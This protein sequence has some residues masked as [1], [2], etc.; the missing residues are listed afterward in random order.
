MNSSI[1]CL[2]HTPIL[3]EYFTSKAYYKDINKTNPLGYEG[4]LAQVSAVLI[5][6]LW[7]KSYNSTPH[8][9]RSPGLNTPLLNAPALTPKTFKE[10]LGKF[11]EIFAGNEQHDA[12]ELLAFLLGGLSEDLNRIVEKPYM[13]APDSDGRPDSELADIWWSNHLKREMSIIVAL[14]TGQYKSLLTCRTCKYESARFEPFSFLQL[15]LPEDDYLSVSLIYYTAKEGCA[16]MKY[17]VRVR[18]DGSL[19]DVLVS[20]AKLLIQDET[21]GNL[22]KSSDPDGAESTALLHDL[23]LQRAR[24]MAI[25][26][27][28]EGYI[29]RMAANSWL[30]QD[31][32]NKDSG[33]LP[34]MH[35]Y[36]FDPNPVTQ[37]TTLNH[38][39]ENGSETIAETPHIPSPAFVAVAQRRSELLSRDVLHPLTHRVFGTPLLLRIHDIDSCTGRDLY[40]QVAR[41]LK[42]VVQRSVLRFLSVSP[43]KSYEDRKRPA[44]GG[45]NDHRL[46]SGISY[47]TLTDMEDV[48]AGPVPRYGFRLRLTS[49][50]GRR[51]LRCAWYESCIGCLIPD[52]D[53]P[54]IVGDGDSIVVDWHFAVD[55]ATNGFGCRNTNGD[56][57]IFANQTAQN[58]NSNR[59]RPPPVVYKNHSSCGVGL[60]NGKQA[61]AVTLEECLDAFSKEE[62]IPEAYC[63]KCKDFRV[64]TKRMSLWRL[65]PV[66]IIHLKRF[67]FTQ[68]MRRKLRDLVVFPTEG[69]DL[70]RIIA[71]DPLSTTADEATT[72]KL[73]ENNQ[74]G[75]SSEELK[76]TGRS[77]MLYDLYGVV[78]HQGALSGG[79][80]VASL[81]SEIDGQWRLFNDA[82]I[83][84][85]HAR[86]V[87]DPSA[88]ILFY[89]RRDVANAQL[90]DYWDVN[91]G[92]NAISDQ[93]MDQL[94]KGRS[95]RCVIS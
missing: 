59:L 24:G 73:K 74:N 29:A 13:E 30:L 94:L 6:E 38:W 55:I 91:Q 79:H 76:D 43:D 87:V 19:H 65:P 33:E 5:N 85:I 61:G 31:Q 34:L 57:A 84:D 75:H 3:R 39:D 88:Y 54:V 37:P 67:Q 16:P 36:E 60:Q 17:C 83:Y 72:K 46:G 32:Q 80:Y 26:V 1:Q 93:D 63:S 81:K 66:M 44:N 8:S 51:C 20:L 70:S 90:S 78:H 48:S 18:N 77:E 41:R 21:G 86:D 69:L 10:S 27:M 95:D 42:G 49:R 56:Y 28:R 92:S 11:N 23:Y 25:V 9:R 52:D 82:Q 47:Q 40:D 45:A 64:Q 62:K 14:F 2:S 53:D 50:D 15:P 58:S 35:V 7:K 12:Q 4:R 22:V 71:T 89:I 68:T